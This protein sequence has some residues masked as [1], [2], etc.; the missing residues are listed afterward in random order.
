MPSPREI[1]IGAEVPHAANRYVFATVILGA[2][3]PEY[4]SIR[5]VS[6]PVLEGSDRTVHLTHPHGIGLDAD[7]NIMI[8]DEGGH[9]VHRYTPQGE[10][11]GQLGKG[12]GSRPG[13]FTSPRAVIADASGN[14]YVTDSK[15]DRSRIQVFSRDGE[16]LRIYA[17]KGTLPGM[18]L[19]AHGMDF[20]SAGRLYTVD[21]DNMRVNVYGPDDKFLYDWGEQGV[22]P[23][24]FN[25]PHGLFVDRSDDVWISSYYGPAQKFNRFGDFIFD[26]CPG[27]PPDGP[28]YFH[29]ST[30][31]QWGNAYICVRTKEGYQGTL[32]RGARNKV[33]IV[34]YNNNGDFITDIT[35]SSPEH[36][37]SSAVVDDR[38]IV[39]A[40][41]E[42]KDA[43]GFE[44]FA[45]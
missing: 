40:L 30:G 43:M 27:D 39:Y 20:D 12:K 16:F 23:G 3:R 9:A 15:G 7:G 38:G 42:G 13:E 14:I 31:D 22:F 21:V 5:I 4:K 32:A 37:E 8:A 25:A 35:L 1:H 29:N 24:Q 10:Y 34:K 11:I 2:A 17:E 41:F 28:V 44:V 26:Y 19:R 18:I 33:S 6:E 45:P 36:K